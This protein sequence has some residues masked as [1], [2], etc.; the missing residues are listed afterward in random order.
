M[1]QKLKVMN[2]NWEKESELDGKMPA[3]KPRKKKKRKSGDRT[4]NEETHGTPSAVAVS[5]DRSNKRMVWDSDFIGGNQEDSEAPLFTMASCFEE[6]GE[7]RSLMYNK[8]EIKA[9][10]LGGCIDLIWVDQGNNEGFVY[11]LNDC[12]FDRKDGS[13]HPQ[14]KFLTES[15]QIFACVPRRVSKEKNEPQMKPSKDNS[16]YKKTYF[17]RYRRQGDF[18]SLHHVAVTVCSVSRKKI[19]VER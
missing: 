12:L 3:E 16:Q 2:L 9:K 14:K 7:T 6:L 1:T 13:K 5:P 4:G 17:V 18:R 19:W 10:S 11:P 8:P 15:T